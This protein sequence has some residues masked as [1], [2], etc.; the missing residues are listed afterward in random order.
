VTHTTGSI[1]W[2][3][4]W[5]RLPGLKYSWCRPPNNFN[6]QGPSAYQ[7]YIATFRKRTMAELARRL[8]L[9]LDVVNLIL[10]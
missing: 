3:S 1:L 5:S 6:F 10:P 7:F 8:G 9:C 2:A 4:Q